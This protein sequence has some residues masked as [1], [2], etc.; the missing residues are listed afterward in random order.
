[1][2][3]ISILDKEIS[4]KIVTSESDPITETDRMSGLMTFIS[5]HRLVDQLRATQ[6]ITSDEEVTGISVNKQGLDIKLEVRSR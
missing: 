5:W 6:E 4:M 2:A 1:M 3:E